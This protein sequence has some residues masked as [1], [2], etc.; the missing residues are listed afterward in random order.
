MTSRPPLPHRRAAWLLVA[1][2]LS[3]LAIGWRLVEVQAL[4]ADRF[5]AL[6]RE[7][8]V[9]RVSLAAERGNIFDRNGNELALSI[10]QHTAWANPR[11]V[12]DP[13]GYARQLAP[14]LVRGDAD[15][16]ALE[17][18]LIERLSDREAAFTY[19]QRKLD[20]ETAAKLE[21]LRLPGVAFVPESERHYPADLALSVLGVVGIDNEGLGGLEL[22]Y[23]KALAGEPGEL[24]VERDPQGRDIPQGLR[25]YSPPTPGVDLILTIDQGLQFEAERALVEAVAQFG[26]VGGRAVILDVETGDILAMASI[27]SDSGG[28]A[29][30]DPT[31]RNRT[32]TDVFEPGSTNKVITISAA[33]EEGLVAPSTEI[34]VPDHLPL[35]DHVFTDHK[36]HPTE[37]WSVRRILKDS[38]NVGAIKIGQMLGKDRLDQYL[39]SFGFGSPTGLDFPGESAGLILD[40]EDWYPTSMGTVPIGNGLAVT[41]LQMLNVFATIANDGVWREPRLVQ[42][43]VDGQGRRHDTPLGSTRR[44][45]SDVTAGHVQ[46]MLTD[47][48]ADGTGTNAA[49]PGYAVA[50]KTGTARKPL[51]GGRGYS[52]RHVASFVGFAP[53]DAPRLAAIV[54]LDEPTPIFGGVVAAPVFSR[55]MR[56][57]LRIE[58]VAPTALPDA[59]VEPPA[60]PNPLPP[61]TEPTDVPLAP[62]PAAGV[63]QVALGRLVRSTPG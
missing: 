61:T 12:E 30:D 48:V 8:R 37:V 9:R 22:Q 42:A 46:D 25:R 35:A 4:S 28:V 33:V 50:G 11:V 1:L 54:V 7:Q 36:P 19:L 20:D 6:G 21:A 2:S 10:P 41:S 62:E 13:V 3:F 38:S 43:T 16:A 47:V 51:E 45:V 23:E 17:R 52:D 55:I 31:E 39:R 49:I 18:E 44:V 59:T 34:V 29:P 14:L 32:I 58:G 27:T 26:A 53:A 40:P 57:A 15:T 63:E 60:E 5:D 24:V 56:N